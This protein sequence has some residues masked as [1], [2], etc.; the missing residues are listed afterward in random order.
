MYNGKII[1]Q[2]LSER[3]ISLRKFQEMM[4]WKNYSQV[5][6]LIDGN[7]TS[8]T[9][10]KVATTL[11]ISVSNFFDE[12]AYIPKAQIVNN[13]YNKNG[14]INV[15]PDLE[16]ALSVLQRACLN[17]INNINDNI[18]TRDK[19]IAL[20]EQEVERLKSENAQLKIENSLL[21]SQNAS[22]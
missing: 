2:I 16:S 21:K 4:G 1:R 7:P 8:D 22:A 5:T 9:L 19:L 14:S 15:G 17:D 3:G 18:K 10:T 13:Q 6:S 20:L 12:S 11:G